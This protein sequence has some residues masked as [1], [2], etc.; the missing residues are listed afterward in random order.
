MMKEIQ[1][2][3]NVIKLKNYYYT[4]GKENVIKFF[5]SKKKK[6]FNFIK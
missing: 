1:N 6:K 2:H 5:Y 3:P 4:Y